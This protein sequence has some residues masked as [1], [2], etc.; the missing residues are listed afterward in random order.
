MTTPK[1]YEGW[2]KSSFYNGLQKISIPLFGILST[3]ILAKGEAL[4]K[5]DMGIWSLFLII[6]SFI[7]VIRHSL[8]KTSLIRYINFTDPRIHKFVLSAAF[9][10][11]AVITGSLSILLMGFSNFI[12]DALKVPPLGNML[13]LFS[14]GMLMLI[15]FSHFEWI[16]N[17]KMLFN[18]LFQVYL[19]RQGITLLLL[20]IGF[21]V[22]KRISLTELVFFYCA[23]LLA[24]AAIGYWFARIFLTGTLKI[25]SS[26]VKQ[27][28]HF[29]KY[30]FG[31][32]ISSLVFRNADQFIVS[33]VLADSAINASQNVAQR[34]LNLADIPSQVLG[35]VLFP[36]SSNADLKNKPGMIKYYYE[37]TVGA[38][39]CAILPVILFILVFP[40]LILLVL[41]GK[42][43]Y[44]AIPYLRV[45]SIT[46]I[47]MAFLKQFGVIIDSS[48][49]PQSNF[50]VITLIAILHIAI[51]YF[52]IDQFGFIGAGYAAV[53]SHLI[54]FVITQYM[55][56]KLYNIS[57]INCFKN[58]F[59]FYPEMFHLLTHK[60]TAKW[61][62]A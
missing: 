50:V 24:G 6:T 62:Q 60:M 8:V 59:L 42:K 54:G 4:T 46:A 23:G 43:Y 7:E 44:D 53:C 9:F 21:F 38:T 5:E 16:L 12:A 58:A 27:L 13:F 55:L 2:L 57:F 39:L 3:M 47:F 18:K 48:G 20:A 56:K 25:A 26:W 19:V 51:T 52:M 35:D 17:G 40:K 34:I 32:G 30:V 14:F 28:W 36:K 29:G 31:T 45:I 1:K 10:I 49:K 37:K 33:R 61:K 11:N 22:Y 41:A 15:P